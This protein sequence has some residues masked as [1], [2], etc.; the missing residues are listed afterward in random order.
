MIARKIAIFLL[1]LWLLALAALILGSLTGCSTA[2]PSPDLP[3]GRPLFGPESSLFPDSPPDDPEPESLA[4]RALRLI[5][6]KGGLEDGELWLSA[7]VAGLGP[8]AA[9]TLLLP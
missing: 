4:D 3:R 2:A 5:K 9:L 8:R 7:T 6:I 1:A